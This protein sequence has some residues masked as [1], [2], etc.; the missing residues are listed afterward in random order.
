MRRPLRREHFLVL[1]T[2]TEE[3]SLIVLHTPL[4]TLL[5][6]VRPVWAFCA[7]STPS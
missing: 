6:L 7:L 2:T 3:D 4:Q 1:N 5:S